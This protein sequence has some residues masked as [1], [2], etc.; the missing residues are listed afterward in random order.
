M[1]RALLLLLL[2]TSLAN[3]QSGFT[4]RVWQI[5]DGLPENTV[6]A[7]TQT[8]DH[9]LW[10]GT[11]GGLVRFDGAR[12]VVFDRDNTPEIH[13]NS[14]FTL[15]CAQDG[16]LWLGTDGGGLV[17]YKDGAFRHYS[18]SDGLM[19]DFVRTVYV[20]PK[21]VL[22]AGTDDGLYRWSAGRLIRVDATGAVPAVAIHA[23]TT[24]RSGAL[25][26][27]GS[28]L[29]RIRG[30]D[31]QEFRLQGS[32]SSAR[33]KSIL[34]TRDGTMWVGT[35]SGLQRMPHAELPSREFQALKSVTST[36]RALREDSS[37]ALLIG[38]IGQGLLRYRDGRLV[39]VPGPDWVPSST[40]LALHE[41]SEGVIW[42][43]MQT[44][45]LRLTPESMATFRLAST[46]NGDFGTIYL[47]R[48]ETL[49]VTG[50]QL[51]HLNVRRSAHQPV[52]RLP[53]S[54]R[55]RNVFRDSKG[56]LW[57]GTEGYGAI[58]IAGKSTK[59]FTRREGL[60]NDFVRVFLE[61]HEGVIW[62]GTDQGVSLWRDGKFTNYDTS[63][64][65]CYPSV[66]D[67]LQDSRGDVW[68]GTD[69]GVSHW[70][71][72]QFVSDAVTQQLSGEKV[73]TIHQDRVGDIWFGTR[74]GGL[75]QWK[76]GSLRQLK[77]TDGLASNIIYKLLEDERGMFW[78][79]GPNGISSVS[80]Y[81][82]DK[83]TPRSGPRPA[84]T[85]Y[86][87]NDGIEATQI[88]GGVQPAGA[89][90]RSGEV[91]FPSNR[92]PV[93]I[94]PWQTRTVEL[95]R[96]VIETVTVDGREVKA[97]D[98]LSVPPGDGRLQIEYSAIQLRS[99]ERIR[100]R[101]RLEG[102]DSEW[103]DALQGRVAH[104]N[105]LPAGHYR[106]RVQAFQMDTPQNFREASF[107]IEWRPHFYRTGWF[108]GLCAAFLTA[109]VFLGYRLT[110]KQMHARFEA[111]LEERSRVARE[112][113]DTVLQGCTGVSA[114]LEAVASLGD[115]D[116]EGRQN[117]LDCA[118]YQLR[119]TAHEARCAVSRLRQDSARR[120]H[121][122][123]SLKDMAEQV[124]R[125]FG[126]TVRVEEM[127]LG[128][129]DS[130]VEHELLMVA[131]EAVSN[132][133][134]HG[135]ATQIR[136]Q[137]RFEENN[138]RV[139]VV[140]DGFGFDVE[141]VKTMCGSHFGL[142]GMRERIERLGGCFLVDSTPGSGTL[143]SFEVPLRNAQPQRAEGSRIS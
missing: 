131:R 136:V 64:G 106:F 13:E 112:M 68:I 123:P 15:A 81:D 109:A 119:A 40:V 122:T 43:G 32:N 51:F 9:Y 54:V 93:R 67:L 141:T 105:N 128:N 85:L 24:D 30:A 70:S 103:I 28:R 89:L 101:Y 33:V 37:G 96:L 90:T 82:L 55:V 94:V 10:I 5:Q 63:S 19:N 116:A 139:R 134:H 104:Y 132:A 12:F 120:V 58:R 4:R 118:R 56:A 69:R 49:W 79:S 143:L 6:Q 27:G 117:L 88:Y 3:S 78:M 48:D 50:A 140:D 62:I 74:G 121:L 72:H 35:I 113:H 65:L 53:P 39:P 135:Q 100:F 41:N 124:S 17:H 115:S 130:A 91:W 45:L 114:V 92:G 138:F 80:R 34:E 126:V 127:G 71:H 46:S 21:G 84:V 110:L 102:L 60:V 129:I 133:V 22:W 86:D 98:P 52:P 16:S 18:R 47:D 97:L 29:I 95:P 25:W 1:L 38:T 99:Q 111:V 142:T 59:S 26:V 73:W 66:R 87:F 2:G 108:I 107:A 11:S 36:V 23:I 57:M 61:D 8:P 83:V 31:V 76:A 42:V 77:R 125:A 14:V 44:G 20:D 7:F 75:Y 137:T